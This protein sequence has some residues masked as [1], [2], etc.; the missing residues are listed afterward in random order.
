MKQLFTTLIL[1]F[2]LSNVSAIKLQGFESITNPKGE[3]FVDNPNFASI[4]LADN[5]LKEGINTSN[6]V[7]AVRIHSGNPDDPATL[8]GA[9]NS[10][11]IKIN[12]ADGVEPKISY[13]ANPL[14][15]GDE[16]PVY[17]DVLRFKL[18]KGN[19]L[20]KN[21][22]FEPLGQPTN[23]KTIKPTFGENEWEYITFNLEY[24]YYSNF[25]LR[26][27]RNETGTGS[28]TGTVAGQII[29]VDDFE[30]YNS[31]IGPDDATSVKLTLEDVPFTC[32]PL[33]NSNFK[34]TANLDKTANVRL[35]LI[36][37]DGKVQTV[38]QGVNSGNT[39]ITFNAKNK[40]F[41]FVRLTLD[42]QKS[43]VQKII[44]Q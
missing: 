22:E 19:L 30:L 29:Y 6:K 35:E 36:S 40:G 32:T 31:D 27:N 21:V 34:V 13:P 37:L 33:E 18:Y 14:G 20:N 44:V 15:T 8:P 12:F 1:A 11:I 7:A 17:Y 38:Y 4:F 24:K 42:N 5:P 9:P 25:Q 10:G 16:I 43:G 23:P 41:H 39:E 3:F 2:V 28:A 26:V